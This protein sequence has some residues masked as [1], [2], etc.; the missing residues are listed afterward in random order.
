MSDPTKS[1][2]A[3]IDEA[4]KEETGT[5]MDVWM[6]ASM[7]RLSEAAEQRS[8]DPVAGD[9]ENRQGRQQNQLHEITKTFID[10]HWTGEYW[11]F[12]VGHAAA[13]FHEWGAQ[14]H[15]I[16]ARK[17]QVLAFEWPDAPEEIQEKFEDTFPTV[18]FDAI[19]H[20]GV[21]GIGF[22]RHGREQAENYLK[23]QGY[24]AKELGFNDDGDS[25]GT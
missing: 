4:A 19:D 1:M 10:P 18:F 2:V 14:P 8:T 7:K 21:P 15:E 23:D 16:R 25:D 6:S 9:S 17:A 20:P 13:V 22:M 5:A 3:A 11:E 24:E 12:A